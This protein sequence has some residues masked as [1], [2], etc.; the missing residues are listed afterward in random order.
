MLDEMNSMSIT[1]QAK[2]LRVLQ[3]GY[4]RRIGGKRDIPID[5]R[6]IATSNEEPVESIEKG[7]IRKDLFF[8]LNVVFISIPPLMDRKGDIPILSKYFT[9]KYNF[10]LGKKVGEISKDVLDSF[11]KY[12]WP[13]NARELENVIE[14]AMNIIS[15]TDEV[16]KKEDFISSVHIIKSRTPGNTFIVNEGNKPLPLILEEI[17]RD[18][19]SKSL[20]RN[21][22]N[23]SHTAVELGIKR[24]TLQH[25]LKRYKK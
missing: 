11:M 14:G 4:I 8:R 3:E 21:E 19:I 24:Q 7:I 23:I 18:M 9:G 13:G 17:E 22:N 5:V 12:H 16:L 25:K 10:I 2:L 15:D 1:L 20:D 6:I